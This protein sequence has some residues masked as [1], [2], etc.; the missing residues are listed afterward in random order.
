MK[1]HIQQPGVR[2]WAAEDFLELQS[3]PLKALDTFFKEYGPCVIEGCNITDNKNNTYNVSAGLV[4]LSGS[5]ADG[6]PTFKVVPIEEISETVLPLYITLSHTTIERPYVDG[7]VKPIAYNYIA[8]TSTIKPEGSCL[9]LTVDNTNRFVD[10]IQNSEHRF[11]TDAERNKLK[12]IETGANKYVHPDNHPASMITEDIDKRFMK[13]AEREKLNGIETGANKYVHPDNHPAEM[14]MEDETHR[15]ITDTERNK[16]KG[17]EVGANK[18]IHPTTPGNK[19]I[20]L[21][22]QAGQFLK[23]ASDG[24]AVWAYNDSLCPYGVGDI[25]ITKSSANPATTWPGTTWKKLEGRFLY[26]TSGSEASGG[27]GGATEVALS[28][29]NLPAHNH[30]VST[31]I[32]SGGGHTHGTNPHSHSTQP[33]I[34]TGSSHYHKIFSSN[35]TT[36]GTSHNLSAGSTVSAVALNSDWS[37]NY[38]MR[39]TI[40]SPNVG[41]TSS[42]GGSNTGSAA[43]YTTEST[44]TVNSGGD[45]SHSASSSCSNTGSG[46]AFSILPSYIKVHMWER[47]S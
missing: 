19:H 15:F 31:S 10:V 14:I 23:W 32:S 30:S 13:D 33:H 17:I 43:P 22:G 27:T 21:G 18:Y 45:H 4:A 11:M 42:D 3:E 20:P 6:N 44:V 24:T 35:Q 40:G 12:G 39:S 5:D 16:L 38:A 47:Q 37:E 9:V 29:A 28:T 7:K 26:G 2:Q 36:A 34:H 8:A 46:N 1:R 41:A 25:F